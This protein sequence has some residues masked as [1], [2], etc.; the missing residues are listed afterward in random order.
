MKTKL[1]FFLFL[2]SIIITNGQT[3]STCEGCNDLGD[4]ITQ[5]E[6]N[7]I[8]STSAQAY[9]WEICDGDATINGSNT[10]QTVSIN[11]ESNQNFT[12]KLIRFINGVCI[13]SCETFTYNIIPPD[14]NDCRPELI[15]FFI[16]KGGRRGAVF[17][18]YTNCPV[19]DN[20]SSIDW[21][22]NNAEFTTGPLAGSS[23]GTI[24]G[25]SSPGNITGDCSTIT[26]SAVIHYNN[27]CEDDY[28]FDIVPIDSPEN[29]PR[30][31][32]PNPT[33]SELKINLSNFNSDNKNI[34]IKI[35][36]LDSMKEFYSKKLVKNDFKTDFK[37]NNLNNYKKVLV[38]IVE[39][40]KILFQSK[41]IIK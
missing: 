28:L 3:R 7:T 37:I 32:Y 20:I 16:C 10:G 17:I 29:S 12:I 22:L 26:V 36:D 8:S 35:I 40:N 21:H 1:I 19:S 34:S 33:K 11:S 2:F 4:N 15:S 41:I 30:I 5:L 14:C 27:G 23:S 13:E 39:N 25:P 6:N 38:S 24:Y 18:D 31:F 9:Y